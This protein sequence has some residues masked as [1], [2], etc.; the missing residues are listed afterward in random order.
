MAN[1]PNGG[2]LYADQPEYR[3]EPVWAQ[4]ESGEQVAAL[5][6]VHKFPPTDSQ[7]DEQYAAA[8]LSLIRRLE[9]RT[10]GL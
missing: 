2:D 5:T 1:I 8:Y 10:D 9:F 4:L 3:P 6:M 7:R